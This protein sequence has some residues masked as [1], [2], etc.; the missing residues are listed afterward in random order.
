MKK[1]SIILSKIYTYLSII[2][3]L[4][5]ASCNFYQSPEK[6]EFTRQEKLAIKGNPDAQNWIGNRYANGDYGVEKNQTQALFWTQKAADQGVPDAQYT[7]GVFYGNGSG[8]TQDYKNAFNWYKRCANNGSGYWQA[9]AQLSL[10]LMYL[11]GKGVKPNRGASYEWCTKAA[12]QG[13][14]AACFYVASWH[15]R[16]GHTSED[17]HI[18]KALLELSASKGFADAQYWLALYLWDGTF[19]EHDQ[20]ASEKWLRKAAEQNHVGAKQL[21]K[22]FIAKGKIKSKSSDSQ[23]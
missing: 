3:I 6:K 21:L 14:P 20:Q 9:K 4:H 5:G 13:E 22:L 10:G 18:A 1:K 7:M 2:F 12:L 19:I 11:E 8:V 23:N 16:A 15:T 17:Q